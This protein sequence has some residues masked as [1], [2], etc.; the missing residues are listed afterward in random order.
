MFNLNW[1]RLKTFWITAM[2]IFTS[3]L[4]SSIAFAAPEELASF[5][6]DNTST[7]Y[8]KRFSWTI[9][10]DTDLVGYLFEIIDSEERYIISELITS[11]EMSGSYTVDVSSYVDDTY[12][13][14]VVPVGP[15]A[16]DV[17][18]SMSKTVTFVIDT[19]AP[20]V[21]VLTTEPAN[22]TNATSYTV[23]WDASTDALS[24]IKGYNVWV[25]GTQVAT[26]QTATTYTFDYAAIGSTDG[27]VVVEV[28]AV[29]NATENGNESAKVSYTFVVDTIAP[30]APTN[31][32]PEQTTDGTM[33][34]NNGVYFLENIVPMF[35]WD[36][37]MD[38]GTPI[39]YIFMITDGEGNVV[40]ETTVPQSYSDTVRHIVNNKLPYG[41]YTM[42]LVAEDAAGNR[43]DEFTVEVTIQVTMDL[44]KIV[45]SQI[46]LVGTDLNTVP[47][48]LG[49]TVAY[50]I[51]GLPTDET[52]REQITM[53]VTVNGK[54]AIV[55]NQLY[56]EYNSIIEE[57]T[58]NYY[59]IMDSAFLAD[60]IG[61]KSY[62]AEVEVK[63]TLSNGINDKIG[64]YTFW[65]KSER[66]GFGFGK[67]RPVL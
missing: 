15:T 30:A 63:V 49:S 14:Q 43:S 51:S 20:T 11:S 45:I 6:M 52:A 29:D 40:E 56:K 58:E 21:P 67:I 19:T 59:I 5:E 32:M 4:F 64:T 48:N 28:S 2:I 39:H 44:N 31:F 24:E 7:K 33:S 41:E 23:E 53:T 42:S 17:D 57:G 62:P 25:N 36:K 22:P 46:H 1:K 50:T 65:I 34:Q 66:L 47:L 35:R 54:E 9:G 27:E 3:L 13:A 37:V 61:A 38:N 26:L 12:K 16:S 8:H 55:G 18:Y 60:A 10:S